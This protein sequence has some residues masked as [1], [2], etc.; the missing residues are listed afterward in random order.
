MAHKWVDWLHQPYRLKG[1]KRFIARDKNG[2]GPQVPT[3]APQVG[4]FATSPLPSGGVPNAAKWGTKTELAH[5][6]ADWLHHPCPLGGP[7]RFTA[8]GQQQ[9][10][11]TSEQI[12]YIISTV[13]GVP[14]SSKRG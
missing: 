11:P 9:G 14:S 1:P 4:R 10:W 13:W 2:S 3:F 8:G 7:H 5:N 6:W 12:G